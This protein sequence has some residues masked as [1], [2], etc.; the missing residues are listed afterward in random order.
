MT[1]PKKAS[2]QGSPLRKKAEAAATK[3]L[4]RGLTRGVAEARREL[5]KKGIGGAAIAGAA[6][7]GVGVLAAEGAAYMATT[8]LLEA[9]EKRIETALNKPMRDFTAQKKKMVAIYGS[10]AETPAPV[11]KYLTDELAR[12]QRAAAAAAAQPDNIERAYKGQGG[13]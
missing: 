10:W 5:A 4:E 7:R 2:S 9:R 11:R 13:K 12:A 1:N 6:A 8:A 3:A